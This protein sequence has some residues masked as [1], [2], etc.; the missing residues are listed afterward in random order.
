MVGPEGG[1]VREGWLR[2]GRALEWQALSS[3]EDLA[4]VEAEGGQGRRCRS[5]R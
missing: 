3:M 2:E 4:S 1:G 5:N